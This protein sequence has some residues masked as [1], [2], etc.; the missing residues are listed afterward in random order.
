MIIVVV[1]SIGV[2]TVRQVRVH[3]A[4][5]LMSEINVVLTRFKQTTGRQAVNCDDCL[6]AHHFSL[7]VGLHLVV[8][9]VENQLIMRLLIVPQSNMELV[10]WLSRACVPIPRTVIESELVSW[11]PRVIAQGQISAKGLEDSLVCTL[12][13]A[14]HMKEESRLTN[15]PGVRSA[16]GSGDVDFAITVDVVAGIPELHG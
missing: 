15:V 2:F 16:V 5:E 14:D 1:P 9:R 3:P 13:I 8:V 6:P 11:L 4:D 12:H 7:H 10:N